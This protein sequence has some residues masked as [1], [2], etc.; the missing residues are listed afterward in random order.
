VTKEEVTVAALYAID[1]IVAAVRE[2]KGRL[3][4]NRV[5][6]LLRD[7]PLDERT[8]T[9]YLTWAPQRYTRNL[10]ARDDDVELIAMC[11]DAGAITAIHDHAASDCAFVL[12]R[13]SLTC[14]NFR[15]VQA[16]DAAGRARVERAAT[17]VMQ[18]GD[19]DL[20]SGHLSVHRVGTQT[21]GAVTLHVYAKPIDAC[22]HFDD[23]GS[24][25]VCASRYDSVPA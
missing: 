24:A 4:P 7:L 21:G 3:A 10:I 5:A 11:W 1:D 13:G 14:E 12:V 16:R 25:R 19:L 18:P 15:L 20:A 23:D 22:T 2:L 17:R 8:L 9:P 6:A